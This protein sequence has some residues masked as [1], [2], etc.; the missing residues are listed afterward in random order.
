MFPSTFSDGKCCVARELSSCI[1]RSTEKQSDGMFSQSFAFLEDGLNRPVQVPQNQTLPL[2]PNHNKRDRS[3]DGAPSTSQHGGGG[4]FKTNIFGTTKRPGTSGG[5]KSKDPQSQ[6]SAEPVLGELTRKTSFRD[7]FNSTPAVNLSPEKRR[8][9][10]QLADNSAADLQRRESEP[11]QSIGIRPKETLSSAHPISRSDSQSTILPN[12]NM[13]ARPGTSYSTYSSA[14]GGPGVV[15]PAL[16]SP[17]LENITYL[18][19]QETS[20]K[21]ISTLDYLRKAYVFQPLYNR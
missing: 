20:S 7:R 5:V 8:P 3:T 9:S 10:I 19:I 11:R 12:V 6:Q 14:G 18:H 4:M 2:P 15:P 17:T 1:H 16:P 13:L 21:R